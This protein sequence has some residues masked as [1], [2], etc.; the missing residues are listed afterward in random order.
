MSIV[1][2]SFPTVHVYGSVYGQK[3]ID[4]YLKIFKFDITIDRLYH[5]SMSKFPVNLVQESFI[6]IYYVPG[7]G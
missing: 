4:Y 5:I 1:K 3:I 7:L 2:D 6:G